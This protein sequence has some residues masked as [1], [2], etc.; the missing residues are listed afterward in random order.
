MTSPPVHARRIADIPRYWSDATP[1]A[2]ALWESGA[3]VTFAELSRIILAG[4][5][6]LKERDVVAGDR[7]MIV[8]EN[9]V[10]EIALLFAAS[11]V[12]AWPVIVNARMSEREIEVIR[13]H[14]QPRVQIFTSAVSADAAAHARRAH[15]ARA[16][17]EYFATVEVSP[18]D[19][20]VNAE[21]ADLAREVATLIYTSGTTGTPK[22]VMVTHRGLLH[23]CGVSSSS[24]NLGA[25][26]RVYAVLPLSHIFGI[27]TVVLSTS[28]AGASIYL[29]P[30]F[31]ARVTL[32]AV[33][34]HDISILQGVPVMFRR[35]LTHL[36]EN[37]TAP[38]FPKLRYLYTG[39]GPLDA[40]L[41]AEVEALFGLP[42]HHGYGMTEYAGSMFITRMDRPRRD[43]SSGEINAGCE[44][45]LVGEGGRDVDPGQAGEIWVRGP[46]TMLGY[47]R[48]P[49]LT[50]EA[51]SDD[52]WLKT[53]DVGRLDPD[54][55]M[56]VVGRSKDLIK[57]SGFNVYPIEIESV[58]NT[59]PLVR[60]SAVVG[61]PL[62]DG[63]EEVVAFIETEADAALD[64]QDISTFVKNK[65]A[66]YKRPSRII[67]VAALPVNANGKVLKHRLQAQL[68]EA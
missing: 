22:G 67:P 63:D 11:E 16:A 20:C 27:A 53:G 24:R 54:G 50:R 37:G 3:P 49:D 34:R 35:L 58:L 8:A 46:G 19:A 66:P 40:A 14:C 61:R 32:D 31:D 1:D 15:A 39:G 12:G 10:A 47:Y 64:V 5:A 26:D 29:E 6:L 45:R 55:A 68:R 30:R 65:L 60:L 62:R 17:G 51:L 38:D 57:R 59:H 13:A 18:T 43:C 21:P 42:L 44:A 48:A 52:G 41:K 4:V 2:P 56:F 28:Y 7:V 33:K 23:F 25:A 36:R 9:C